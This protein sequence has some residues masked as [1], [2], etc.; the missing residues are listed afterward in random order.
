[1]TWFEV[2][3]M[4]PEQVQETVIRYLTKQKQ[5]PIKSWVNQQVNHDFVLLYVYS[6]RLK[7]LKKHNLELM[8]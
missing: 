4:L 5:K 8:R 7:N 6:Y 2:I 3:P 1:M